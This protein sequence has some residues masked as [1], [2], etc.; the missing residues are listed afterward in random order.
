MCIEKKTKQLSRKDVVINTAG[1][2]FI[3]FF[4][5]VKL[6]LSICLCMQCIL[7]HPLSFSLVFDCFNLPSSPVSIYLT[8]RT[9]SSTLTFDSCCCCCYSTP[10]LSPRLPPSLYYHYC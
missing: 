9:L 7:Y 3:S 2:D 8:Y 5:Y 4:S 6:L 1:V 10:T